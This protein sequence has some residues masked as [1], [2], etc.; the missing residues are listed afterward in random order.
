MNKNTAVGGRDK[1]SCDIFATERCIEEREGVRR[2]M[3]CRDR[4]E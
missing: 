2:L 4:R 3:R 1:N